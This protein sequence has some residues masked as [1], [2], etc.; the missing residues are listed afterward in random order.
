MHRHK[1]AADHFSMVGFYG[2]F[3]IVVVFLYMFLYVF[4]I[5]DMT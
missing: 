4:K 1:H 2:Y 3:S 5:F